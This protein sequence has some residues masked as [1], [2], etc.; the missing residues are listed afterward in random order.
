MLAVAFTPVS[1]ANATM[2]YWANLN[3]DWSTSSN[4]NVPLWRPESWSYEDGAGQLMMPWDNPR[5]PPEIQPA[6][7]GV[8]R[9]PADAPFSLKRVIDFGLPSELPIG[10]VGGL[11]FGEDPL[12]SCGFRWTYPVGVRI[13]NIS[14]VAWLVGGQPVLNLTHEHAD[15]G[16]RSLITDATITSSQS[17]APDTFAALASDPLD[18]W[19]FSMRAGDSILAV[20]H[21]TP[22]EPTFFGFD[23]TI[24]VVPEPATLWLLAVGGLVLIRRKR[25]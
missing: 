11:S 5:W 23:M 7:R 19:S 4:P 2:G 18:L 20:V 1:T 13:M 9:G 10:Q 6:W 25:R 16:S 3:E 21:G 22:S 12:L 8:A 15:G 14:G 24:A 17:S